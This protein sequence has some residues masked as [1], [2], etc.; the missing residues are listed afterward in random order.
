MKQTVGFDPSCVCSPSFF[1]PVSRVTLTDLLSVIVHLMITQAYWKELAHVYKWINVWK[2]VPPRVWFSWSPAAYVGNHHWLL[3]SLAGTQQTTCCQ[4]PLR[5]C[6]ICHFTEL[7]LDAQIWKWNLSSRMYR[8]TLTRIGA[9]NTKAPDIKPG[10]WFTN[11]LASLRQKFSDRSGELGE[12]AE[13]GPVSRWP[14]AW[15]CFWKA[16][17]SADWVNPEPL[18]QLECD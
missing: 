10:I 17:S 8:G 14:L 7:E 4:H 5:F 16:H 18:W 6:L 2:W 3:D 12:P 11:F 1:T 15:C 9:C 13:T